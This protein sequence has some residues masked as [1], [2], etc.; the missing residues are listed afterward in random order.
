MHIPCLPFACRHA[1]LQYFT[2]KLQEQGDFI[3]NFKM[4]TAE[5][6]TKCR[7]LLSA[8]ALRRQPFRSPAQE[9]SAHSS[10]LV[11]GKFLLAAAAS[12]AALTL[13]ASHLVCSYDLFCEVTSIP[14]ETLVKLEKGILFS[15]QTP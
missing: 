5:R 13:T 14:K 4:V 6:L 1:P 12:M 11:S 7:A 3:T 10:H 2:S 9:A 8:G 15:R